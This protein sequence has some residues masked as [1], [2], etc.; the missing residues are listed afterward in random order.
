MLIKAVS[1]GYKHLDCSHHY[2]R[3]ARWAAVDGTIDIGKRNQQQN[4]QMLHMC[5]MK[6]VRLKRHVYIKAIEDKLLWSHL[7]LMPILMYS[8]LG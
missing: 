5:C 8:T 3:C 7:P 4:W 6:I 2:T 1:Q